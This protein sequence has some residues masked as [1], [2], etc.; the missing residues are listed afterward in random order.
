MIFVLVFLGVYDSL[1]IV[2][3]WLDWE[4]HGVGGGGAKTPSGGGPRPGTQGSS[5]PDFGRATRQLLKLI[6]RDY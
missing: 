2:S 3:C 1:M 5:M 4:R 6:T